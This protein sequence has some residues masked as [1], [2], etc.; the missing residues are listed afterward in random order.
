MESLHFISG[1]PRSG[2]TLLAGILRQNPKFHAHMTSPVMLTVMA[3]Y[4]A[5]G[6]DQEGS[7]FLTEERRKAVVRGAI[8]G[9]YGNLL[10][11]HTVFDTNRGW[12]A[13]MALLA[14]LYP[15]ARIIACV[16]DPAWIMD[17]F[18]RVYTRNPFT[19]SQIFNSQTGSTLYARVEALGG[20]HGP[21]GYAWH[22]LREAFYGPHAKR[23]ILLDYEMLCR[24]PQAAMAFVYKELGLA[25]FAHD[26]DAVEYTDGDAFDEKM[27]VPG[28]HEVRRKVE[29]RERAAILPPDLIQRFSA[30]AFWM[31][32]EAAVRGVPMAI[33]RRPGPAP[34]APLG[35]A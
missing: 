10:D 35:R 32:P 19:Q 26:F 9:Y 33:Y 28:L 27:G 17:S 22:A 7:V 30:D 8:Q 2:S 11:T 25:P 23:L 24:Q 4:A 18:E 12:T 13:R 16:R 5:M 1:L 3:L 31:T 21:V 14:S 6:A 20:L 29:F 15:K 34:L